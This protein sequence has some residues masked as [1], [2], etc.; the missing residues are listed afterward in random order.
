M[1]V[2]IGD[3]TAIAI[4]A[5]NTGMSWSIILSGLVVLLIA[6]AALTAYCQWEEWIGAVLGLWL[7]TSP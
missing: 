7:I 5:G 2:P 1:T 4:G 3:V 6:G